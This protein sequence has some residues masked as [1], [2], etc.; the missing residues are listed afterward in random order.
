MDHFKTLESKIF[1]NRDKLA[2]QVNLW[3]EKNEKIVFTNGCFD[4]L[5]RG[6]ISYLSQAADLGTKLI[7]GLNADSSVQL[8]KGP[9]RPVIDQETRAMKLAAMFFIDAVVLFEEETPLN[10]IKAIT[11]DVLVKGGDYNIQEIVGYSHVIKAGGLVT[12]VPFVAGQSSTNI[13]QRMNSPEK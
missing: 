1:S 7:I 4:I 3:K 13:I 8:L 5:H 12:T 9:T 2:M 10:L 6:H 11:P